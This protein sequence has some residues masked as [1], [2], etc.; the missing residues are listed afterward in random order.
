MSVIP[1]YIVSRCGKLRGRPTGGSRTCSLEGCRGV[2][3]ATKWPDD[4]VTYPCSDGVRYRK[5]GGA[6]II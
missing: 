6:R 5:D 4:Q 1:K 2:R 3:I